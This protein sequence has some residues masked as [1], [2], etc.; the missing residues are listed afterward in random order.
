MMGI[1]H[2]LFRPDVQRMKDTGDI[3]G[4]IKALKHKQSNIRRS[5]ADPLC[6]NE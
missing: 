3:T 1:F 5:A 2:K 6:Q 4:L